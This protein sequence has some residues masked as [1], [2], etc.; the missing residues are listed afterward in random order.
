MSQNFFS[1]RMD[2]YDFDFDFN[3]LNLMPY[4]IV[5]SCVCDNEHQCGIRAFSAVHVGC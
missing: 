5:V 2:D 4:A 3:P 1:K